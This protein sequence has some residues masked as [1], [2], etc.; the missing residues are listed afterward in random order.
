M[1]LR[2]TDRVI[3]YIINV[4]ILCRL[5]ESILWAGHEITC[6]MTKH[7]RG[8]V[9]GAFDCPCVVPS[10]THDALCGNGEGQGF[11][12]GTTLETTVQ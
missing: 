1:L 5:G 9:A 2:L 12:Q 8:S 4:R 10:M 6:M 3:I 7:E 11:T